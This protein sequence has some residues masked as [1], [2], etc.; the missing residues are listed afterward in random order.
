MICISYIAEWCTDRCNVITN[1]KCAEFVTKMSPS[2]VPFAPLVLPPTCPPFLSVLTIKTVISPLDAVAELVTTTTDLF[3]IS[4]NSLFSIQLP[5]KETQRKDP[6]FRTL[7]CFPD[8]LLLRFLEHV[9]EEKFSVNIV[10]ATFTSHFLNHPFCIF[11]HLHIMK[12]H[13]ICLCF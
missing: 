11:I 12:Y 3:A 9:T 13:Q 4:E 5:I 6:F 1:W 8:I 2:S 7:S 10:S